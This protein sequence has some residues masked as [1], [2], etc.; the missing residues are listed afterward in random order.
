MKKIV[1]TYLTLEDYIG[2]VIAKIVD[3]CILRNDKKEK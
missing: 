2:N 3:I 1:L